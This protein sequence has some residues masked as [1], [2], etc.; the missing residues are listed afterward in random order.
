MAKKE[1]LLQVKIDGADKAIT[2]VEDL[3]EA[4]QKLSK[5][6]EEAED[7]KVYAQ[8]EKD[9]ARVSKT[10]KKVNTDVQKNSKSFNGFRGVLK[11]VNAGFT[12]LVLNPIGAT[13][14]AIAAVFVLLCKSLS[15]TEEGSNSL[16]KVLAIGEGL[17]TALLKAIEPL[18]LFVADK[19][20]G[21]FD[22]LV[23]NLDKVGDAVKFVTKA[24]T[25]L[26]GFVAGVGE[27]IKALGEGESI[28]DSW[29]RGWEK[30]SEVQY[31]YKYTQLPKKVRN[32]YHSMIW[33]GKEDDW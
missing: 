13:I 7:P 2:S 12:A 33:R 4:Q 29:S 22:I 24:F 26:K 10:L 21:A 8:I 1:I 27:S 30:G 28:A 6:L 20:V 32:L 17:F 14:A 5:A 3:V 15:R 11:K 31:G 25:G 19:L 23:E 18:A 9:L 16:N